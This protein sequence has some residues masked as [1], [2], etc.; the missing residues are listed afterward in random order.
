MQVRAYSVADELPYH[1][2]TTHLDIP[3]DGGADIAD[4]AACDSGPDALVQ[5]FPGRVEQRLRLR[6]RLPA[7]KVPRYRRDNRSDT[8]PH[9]R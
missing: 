7:A 1:R 3:L 9:P 6:E 4:P 5:A 8:R 2:V